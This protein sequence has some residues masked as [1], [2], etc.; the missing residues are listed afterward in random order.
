M[1]QRISKHLSPSTVIATLAL[2]FAMSGGAY[3]ASHYLITKTSQIKPSVLKRLTGKAAPAGPAG[4]AGPVGPAGPAGPAGGGIAGAPG[5]EG[6]EGKSGSNGISP[7][8]TAFSGNQ[9]GCAEGGVEVKGASTS[10]VCNGV[11]GANGQ[12]GFTKVLP[13]GE[14]EVGTFATSSVPGT[15]GVAFPITF[16][17]PLPAP[18][19]SGEIHVVGSTPTTECPGSPAAPQAVAQPGETVLCAYLSGSVGLNTAQGQEGI[20]LLPMGPGGVIGLGSREGEDT[21]R[22]FGSFAV[23]RGLEP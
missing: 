12:T 17:I 14:T 5:K 9:H 18:L 13:A 4:P 16:S 21:V 19:G 22:V 8:S 10:F 15:A 1:F 11:K 3:A 7:T 2:V 23:T 6:P 20:L